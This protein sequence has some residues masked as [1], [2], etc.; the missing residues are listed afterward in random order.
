MIK[1]LKS[2][3]CKTMA[4]YTD[5][6]QN[7]PYKKKQFRKGFIWLGLSLLGFV[8]YDPLVNTGIL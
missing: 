7:N 6:T 1:Q 4:A 8:A 3:S 5:Q 2:K